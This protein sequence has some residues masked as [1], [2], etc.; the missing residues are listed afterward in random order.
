MVSM[1]ESTG[2][3]LALANYCDTE[4]D[5]K[6]LSAGIRWEG[7]NSIIAGFFNC[8]ATTSFSQNIGVVGVTRVASRFVVIAAGGILVAAGLLPKLGALIASVPQP[9]IGGA[10]L[11]MFGMILSGGIG[12]IKSIEFSRR[13]SMVLT[14]GV[15]TGLAVTYRPELV[16]QLPSAL[17]T[18]A[19]NGI[20]MGAIITVL[21]NLILPEER[22]HMEKEAT[23]DAI[24]TSL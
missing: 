18:V 21:A 15:A 7:V 14:L 9:V 1:V 17:Q 11:I 13:N 22:E 19:G 6:R 23:P 10:G 16:T 2:D 5:S 12:I 24:E 20:A 8:T 4:L 3:Y